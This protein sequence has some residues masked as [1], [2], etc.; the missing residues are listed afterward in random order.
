MLMCLILSQRSLTLFSFLFSFLYSVLWQC[1][2]FFLIIP[3]SS[4][5]ICSFASLI[6]LLVFSSISFISIIVF[7]SGYLLFKYSLSFLN[8]SHIFLVFCHLSFSEIC[9]HLYYHYL[10]CFSGR[11]PISTSLSYSSRVL[12]YSFIWNIFSC[13][14]I[15]FNFLCPRLQDCSSSHFWCLLPGV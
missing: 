2:F 5:L 14:L 4:S 1:F 12:S 7:I 11:L 10:N 3:S 9:L 13:H 8:I 15:L 6:L